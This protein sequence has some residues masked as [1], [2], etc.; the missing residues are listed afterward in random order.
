M[1]AYDRQSYKAQC[2]GRKVIHQSQADE[3]KANGGNDLEYNRA[4][5]DVIPKAEVDER[6]LQQHEKDAS[7]EQPTAAVPGISL[8]GRQPGGSARQEDKAGSA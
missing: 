4:E 3:P 7:F 2:F 6:Q 8:S 1:E 5:M